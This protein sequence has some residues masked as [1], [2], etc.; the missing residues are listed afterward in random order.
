MLLGKDDQGILLKSDWDHKAD[1]SP[2]TA[3]S[4]KLFLSLSLTQSQSMYRAT[5]ASF[6]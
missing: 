3:L 2:F 5:M 4:E 1:A 6:G